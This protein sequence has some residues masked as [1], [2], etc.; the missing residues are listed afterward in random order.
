MPNIDFL[1]YWCQIRLLV[2]HLSTHQVLETASLRFNQYV[3]Y[4]E[5][6]VNQFV[7]Q[8]MAVQLMSLQERE[9]YY[10]KN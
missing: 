7:N 5:N 4:A 6:A 8:A 2:A 3:E 9:L 10:E 1:S